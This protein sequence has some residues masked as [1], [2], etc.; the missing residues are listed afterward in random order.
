LEEFLSDLAL[1]AKPLPSWL[2]TYEIPAD[3]AD[4]LREQHG[5]KFHEKVFPCVTCGAKRDD[6][7]PHTYLSP[8]GSIE[9]DCRA[10][11][12]LHRFLLYSGLG[13]RYMRYSWD[14]VTG[15][16]PATIKDVVEYAEHYKEYASR[17]M[18]LVLYSPRKGTGKTL[19]GTLLF[20]KL[21]S[22]RIDGY[23]VIWTEMLDYY[24]DG[25][26][27]S[28]ARRWFDRRVRNAG[29]LVIDDVGREASSEAANEMAGRAL[30]GVLRQRVYH[31]L[32]TIIT[33]NLTPG[34]LGARYSENIDSLLDE[35]FTEVEVSTTSDWRPSVKDRNKVEIRQGVRRPVTFG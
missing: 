4:R 35:T 33:T 12:K 28:G 8:S 7:E 17:G 30:E 19:L 18:G 3:D 21:L 15:V 20:K 13:D 2:L 32:P 10:Q 29:V 9:C 26:R 27:D 22:A 6:P 25:W 24:A 31:N 5:P 11:F 34:Q 14:D 23:F 1:T 16:N